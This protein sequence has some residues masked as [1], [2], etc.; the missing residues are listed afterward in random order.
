MSSDELIACANTPSP[1]QNIFG[2]QF[3]HLDNLL[4]MKYGYF[5]LQDG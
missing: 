3:R 2:N 4:S 5:N 1:A